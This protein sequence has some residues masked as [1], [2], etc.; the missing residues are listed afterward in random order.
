MML[1]AGKDVNPAADGKAPYFSIH[2][3]CNGVGFACASCISSSGRRASPPVKGFRPPRKN[4]ASDG[5]GD[6][7]ERRQ[8]KD[9]EVQ[10]GKPRTVGEE[11]E[12]TAFMYHSDPPRRRHNHKRKAA[13]SKSPTTKQSKGKAK[14]ASKGKRA[15]NAQAGHWKGARAPLERSGQE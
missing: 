6:A 3:E 2:P 11:H 12:E 1:T 8:A 10:Y 9:R 7:M 13:P 4:P 5:N 15:S 14:G